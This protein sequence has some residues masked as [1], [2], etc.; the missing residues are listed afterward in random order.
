MG[1][2]LP[3]AQVSPVAGPS[4][5]PP[6]PVP[7]QASSS[8][9]PPIVLENSDSENDVQ[10]LAV[11]FRSASSEAYLPMVSTDDSWATDTEFRFVFMLHIDPWVFFPLLSFLIAA[12]LAL[13]SLFYILSVIFLCHAV[14]LVPIFYSLSNK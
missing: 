10:T 4:G 8:A 14:I 11:P 2:P 7:I 5:A 1:L 13:G 12:S 9:P 3:A 6:V